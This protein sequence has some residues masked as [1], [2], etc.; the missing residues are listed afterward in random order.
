MI[1]ANPYYH[2]V[3]SSRHERAVRFG[4]HN[5]KCRRNSRPVVV[6][7]EADDHAP[8]VVEQKKMKSQGFFSRAKAFV[9]ARFGK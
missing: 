5:R 7:T 9:S 4:W 8:Q 3:Q 6:Q 1:K 2:W